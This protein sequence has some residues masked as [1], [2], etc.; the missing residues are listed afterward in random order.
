MMGCNVDFLNARP[1]RE[2]TPP[3]K[4]G[5]LYA[6]WRVYQGKCSSCHGVA[7]TGGQQAPDLLPIVRSLNLQQFAAIVLKRYDL[8]SGVSRKSQDKTTVETRID[9]IM[10]GNEPPIEMPTW[11]GEPAVN[12]HILDLYTYLSARAEGR[13]GIGRPPDYGN[14]SAV[15]SGGPAYWVHSPIISMVMA[16]LVRLKT[17]VGLTRHPHPCSTS[18]WVFAPHSEARVHEV[19]AKRLRCL[20]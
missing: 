2:L 8:A 18:A 14:T 13:I 12:A 5:N 17:A 4:V 9:E 1:A 11:Q 3:A 7:A 10:R 19:P 16:S 6:G 20:C 15:F